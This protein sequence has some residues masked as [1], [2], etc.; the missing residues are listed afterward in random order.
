LVVV[1]LALAGV[2]YP[3]LFEF[4]GGEEEWDESGGSRIA[5]VQRVLELTMRNPITGL[6]PASYRVYAY[7]QPFAYGN[8][9]WNSP[10]ISSHNNYVDVFAQTGILGLGLFIWFMAEVIRS[11][12][13]AVNVQDGMCKGLAYGILATTVAMLPLM[14]LAD[15]F[16][17]F[18]Y[19][20]G[21]PGFQASV[22][23][24]LFLGC[25]VPL[26]RMVKDQAPS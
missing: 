24:W 20:I 7:M 5:L 17:P 6:G 14:V 1:A 11:S 23:V 2:L 21:F 8:A 25:L 26:E 19:N 3:T 4:A 13:R 12:A 9:V 16:L 18:V 15:W 22:L 10:Q